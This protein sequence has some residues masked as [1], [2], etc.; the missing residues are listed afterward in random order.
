MCESAVRKVHN[1]NLHEARTPRTKFAK[2]SVWQGT[3]PHYHMSTWLLDALLGPGQKWC[4]VKSVPTSLS[5]ALMERNERHDILARK[6]GKGK[7]KRNTD[8]TANCSESN[9]TDAI[10]LYECR[11][12]S[13]RKTFSVLLFTWQ[14]KNTL[15][16]LGGAAGHFF[17]R[18]APLSPRFRFIL[19]VTCHCHC[20]RSYLRR[21]RR[22]ECVHSNSLFSRFAFLVFGAPRIYTLCVR[23]VTRRFRSL[24]RACS[25]P[26]CSVVVL[27]SQPHLIPPL[28]G[29]EIC[30]VRL[31]HFRTIRM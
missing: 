6:Q 25:P 4:R 24:S 14:K 30:V 9:D 22:H 12:F 11:A 10:K 2:L 29:A 20:R 27:D 5:L 28:K 23:R 15:V 16:A 17:F 7:K 8:N 18:G 26:P 31:Q 1:S 13:I 21:R 19:F 3:T